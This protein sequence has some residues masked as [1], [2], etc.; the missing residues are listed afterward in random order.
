MTALDLGLEADA[1]LRAAQEH[2]YQHPPDFPGFRAAV[3]IHDGATVADGTVTVPREGA[4]ELDVDADEAT[5]AWA[6]HE[7]GSMAMH[8]R[9][10]SYEDGDGRHEK[11]LAPDDGS[12]LGRLVVLDDAM[13][14]TFR[15]REGHIQEISRSHGGARFTIAI[16]ERVTAPDGRSVSSAFTVLFQ[17]EQT[18]R[19][20]RAH[21]YADGHTAVGELLLPGSRQVVTGDEDGLR[22]RRLELSG[23]ELL[24]GSR[25]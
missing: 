13:A 25:S 8:R 22:V 6:R 16:Q 23:H 21:V 15:I 1:L 20:T 2:G 9:H 3:R 19:L 11:R 14:S 10:R 4:P 12:P 5:L 17:D 18:G 24:D 7:L